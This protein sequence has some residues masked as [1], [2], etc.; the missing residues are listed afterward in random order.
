MRQCGTINQQTL[1][2]F[3]IAANFMIFVLLYILG[4]IIVHHIAERY[5]RKKRYRPPYAN[6]M[7]YELHTGLAL[8]FVFWPAIVPILVFFFLTDWIR[9]NAEH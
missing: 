9:T 1:I 4:A 3:M 8:V 5:L 7:K 6:L 2:E